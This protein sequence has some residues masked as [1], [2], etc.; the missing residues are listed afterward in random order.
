MPDEATEIIKQHA[1]KINDSYIFF[2]DAIPDKKLRNAIKSYATGARDSDALVLIDNTSWGSAKSGVLLT[3]YE[4]YAKDD[5]DKPKHIALADI[6]SVAFF[7]KLLESRLMINGECFSVLTMPD[8]KPLETF[9]ELLAE[10]VDKIREENL[11]M[12]S[13]SENQ[14]EEEVLNIDPSELSSMPEP[15]EPPSPQKLKECPYCGETIL[16]HAK[17]CKHCGEFLSVS[18][19]KPSKGEQESSTTGNNQTVVVKSGGGCAGCLIATIIGAII[20]V[21]I[22]LFMGGCFLDGIGFV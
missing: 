7:P 22:F 6:Q 17:K 19:T 5:L 9:T 12:E 11:V 10:L 14:P 21:L 1:H 2:M 4:L 3:K 15:N 18:V 13:P 16:A 20:V 8:K